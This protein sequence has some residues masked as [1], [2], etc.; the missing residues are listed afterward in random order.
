LE[1][2]KVLLKNRTFFLCVHIQNEY[3]Y[4]YPYIYYKQF[5]QKKNN[6]KTITS[7]NELKRM[8]VQIIKEEISQGGTALNMKG[9]YQQGQQQG[10]SAGQATKKAV[11]SGI[12]ELSKIGKQ[13][14]VKIGNTAFT[15]ITVGVGA[16]AYTVWAIGS[17]IWK[18]STAASN[19]A[20]KLYSSV[21]KL[22]V[23]A[24]TAISTATLNL[25]KSAGVAI[26]QGAQAF[27]NGIKALQD[28]GTAVIKWVVGLGKQFG[29]K[30]W[31]GIM[32]A[33]SK[34]GEIA[35]KVGNW[36][37][38][39]WQTIQKNVGIG[40]EKA[41]QLG[42]QAMSAIGKGAAAVGNAAR[43]AL[44]YGSKLAGNVGGFIKGLF[45]IFERFSS[46]T[47]NTTLGVLSE[48]RLVSGYIL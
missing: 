46:F 24:A 45:E 10:M 28:K 15:I 21:G 44:N 43:G 13:V 8:I 20:L 17:G 29:A 26:S 41:K 12:N 7:K 27:M 34:I 35:S 22:A 47:S 14:I 2:K 4:Y 31:A 38:Q 37:G 23:G 36:M 18:I 5:T 19:A 48:A 39:Q 16:A 6:M 42:S 33:A 11:V 25:L 30:V 3:F 32:A 9:S 1:I 40:W